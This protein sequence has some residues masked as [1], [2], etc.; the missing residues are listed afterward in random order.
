[1]WDWAPHRVCDH[2]DVWQSQIEQQI[3]AA[4]PTILTLK[5]MPQAASQ[6]DQRE[7]RTR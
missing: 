6:A 7:T 1:L 2:I 5:S 3:R 4:P